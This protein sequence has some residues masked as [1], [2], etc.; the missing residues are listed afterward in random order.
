[1]TRILPA[2]A[3]G[4]A[5][6]AATAAHAAGDEEGSYDFIFELGNLLLLA[7]VLFYFARK[8]VLEYFAGRRSEI[9]ENIERSEKLL[10]DAQ[11]RLAE[12]EAKANGLEAEVAQIKAATKRAAEKQGEDM[13]AA[14]GAIAERIRTSAS[15]T[16]DR[17]LFQAREH[18]RQEAADLA[19]EMAVRILRDNVSEADR[20]RLV[21]EFISELERGGTA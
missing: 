20:S 14:A 9:Q 1:M 12:W 5:L 16:V 18:L 6:L 2:L 19:V 11:D 4:F 21:D 10:T 17:E 8:P 15:A 7:G 13:I 3:V